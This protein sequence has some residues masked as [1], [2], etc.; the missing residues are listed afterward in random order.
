VTI[1]Q[2]QNLSKTRRVKNTLM[3]RSNWEK[4][5]KREKLALVSRKRTLGQV[6]IANGE[7]TMYS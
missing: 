7:K 3:S 6:W 4:F 2:K 1:R 5:W